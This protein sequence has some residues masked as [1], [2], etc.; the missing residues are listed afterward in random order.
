MDPRSDAELLVAWRAGDEDSGRALLVRHFRPLTRFFR[1]K[2]DVGV[3]DLIQRTMLVC[4]EHADRLRDASSFRAYLFTIARNE[5]YRHL[6]RGRAE[7]DLTLC[8][9]HDLQPSQGT[10]LVRR[11]EQR[12]LLAALRRLPLELQVTVELYYW[13]SC[14]YPELAE[15]LGVHRETIKSRLRRA[16]EL[17]RE[18]IAE[19]EGGAE[20]SEASIEQLEDWARAL[21]HHLTHR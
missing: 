17:L 19:I 15:I 6:R 13:E 16:K 4:L 9:I 2:V 21:R 12:I 1:N 18:R 20:L 3:E 8:S 14:T 10:Q 7:L 5:L 11:E